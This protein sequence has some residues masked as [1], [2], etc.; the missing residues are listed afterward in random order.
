MQSK[1]W[2]KQWEQ[3]APASPEK[4]PWEKYEETFSEKEQLRSDEGTVMK[5]YKDSR[6]FLTGGVGRLLE[7]KG[8]KEGQDLPPQLV[9]EWFDQDYNTAKKDAEE[10]LKGRDVPVQ[11]RNV[12]ENMSFNLGKPK[13]SNFK[14]ML[15]N[16][17]KKN[18]EEVAY[19]LYNSDWYN[20]VPNRADRL[21]KR[22]LMLGDKGDDDRGGATG[23]S[24][25][26]YRSRLNDWE[27]R[28]Q[29][30]SGSGKSSN[31]E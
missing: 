16:V 5:V 4:K 27:K 10:L 11:F 9:E 13:L 31:E 28:R 18:W 12:L 30:E 3:Q 17:D 23:S 20:Q 19:E 7:G 21:I 29:S 15:D 8:Y 1:P 2:E 14:D 22:V 26:R 6:G 25:E 24:E